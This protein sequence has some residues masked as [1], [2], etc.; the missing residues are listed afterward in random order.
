AVERVIAEPYERKETEPIIKIVQEYQFLNN[1]KW[2]PIKLSSELIFPQ[3]AFTIADSSVSVVSR[4]STY[5]DSVELNPEKVKKYYFDNANFKVNNTAGDVKDSTWNELR[6]YELTDKE[7][8]TYKT[9]DS[10]AK[11][12]KL[13]KLVYGLKVLTTGKIP[14]KYINADLSRLLGYNEYEGFRLGLG[15]ETSDRLFEPASLGGY[16]AYGF[17]DKAFKWGGDLRVHIYPRKSLTLKLS[18]RDDVFERGQRPYI[19]ELSGYS[20]ISQ[21]RSLY[22]RYMDRYRQAIA[23]LSIYAS[24]NFR[25]GVEGKYERVG[26]LQGYRHQTFQAYT[27]F[28]TTSLESIDNFAL[29]ASVL[30][31]IR[32]KVVMLGNQRLSKGSKYPT[33]FFSASRGISGVQLSQFNY[34]RL[35]AELSHKVSIRGVGYFKYSICAG[36]LLGDVPL[37]Y[38]FGLFN[39]FSAQYKLNLSISNTFETLDNL[40]FYFQKNASVFTRFDFNQWKKFKKFKPQIGVHNAVGFG[41]S[42]NAMQSTV[43]IRGLEKGH[44]ET[45]LVVNNLLSNLGL[46]V[47]YRYGDYKSVYELQNLCVK[48]SFTFTF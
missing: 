29:T 31:S 8:N 27:P 1:A 37:N 9:I 11:A 41:K 45:G 26:F 40:G 36:E 48:L 47:F 3:I 6:K 18:Y 2:F 33:L 28:T 30:W 10:I 15:L 35:Y 43:P 23:D 13:D 19:D 24:S 5:I 16:F 22:V 39:S 42:A 12:E 4:S 44:F 7:K 32:E 14:L 38:T 20:S 46:G 17:R 34:T 21:L 25:V